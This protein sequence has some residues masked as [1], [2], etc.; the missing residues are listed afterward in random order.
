[1][2]ACVHIKG[3]SLG[4][5]R[6]GLTPSLY[7]TQSWGPGVDVATPRP[8]SLVRRMG[9]RASASR[10]CRAAG[11]GRGLHAPTWHVAGRRWHVAPLPAGA[12]THA[13]LPGQRGGPDPPSGP[14]KEVVPQPRLHQLSPETCPRL[15]PPSERGPREP[16]GPSHCYTSPRTR[17]TP[18]PAPS[19]A[20]RCPSPGA[21]LSSRGCSQPP[22]WRPPGAL[23]REGLRGSLRLDRRETG[24]WLMSD[25]GQERETGAG[26]RCP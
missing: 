10:G 8:S 3:L 19:V 12:Q 26:A 13:A 9:T 21:R 18:A 15:P 14:L 2:R 17:R 5:H 6:P 7:V 4:P 22:G 24:L 20:P 11:E 25:V 16:A 23:G 1:M